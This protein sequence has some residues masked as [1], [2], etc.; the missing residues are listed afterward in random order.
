[1][2]RGHQEIAGPVAGEH[3]S[4]P[5]RA[6]CGGRQSHEQQ[7]RI[8][9]AK[10]GNRAAPVGVAPMCAFLLVRDAAT[11]LSQARA[12]F[13]RNNR[14]VDLSE[15]GRQLDAQPFHEINGR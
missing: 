5:V 4:G 7:S 10:S 1:M 8:W 11:V 9:I 12:A 14:V 2:E 13:A 3:A 15:S 6:V